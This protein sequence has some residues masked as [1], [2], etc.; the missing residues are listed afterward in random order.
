MSEWQPIETAPRDGTWFCA[1]QDGDVY[2]CQW[3]VD[4]DLEG[5]LSEGWFDN[6]NSSFEAPT[7]W[8]SLPPEGTP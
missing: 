3:R 8:V 4:D 1:Y 6:V 5:G 7:L 2:K